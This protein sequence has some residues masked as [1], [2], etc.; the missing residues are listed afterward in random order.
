LT[1]LGQLFSSYFD[2]PQDSQ[3]G[4]T[5]RKNAFSSFLKAILERRSQQVA[6]WLKDNMASFL[7]DPEAINIQV[8]WPFYRA[9]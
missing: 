8:R 4:F 9:V 6:T 7:K 1:G 3:Q 5:V 2:M